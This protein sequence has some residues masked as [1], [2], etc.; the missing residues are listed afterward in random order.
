MVFFFSPKD[1]TSD[2]VE[3]ETLGTEFLDYGRHQISYEDFL[4]KVMIYVIIKVLLILY[5]IKN[6]PIY[7]IRIREKI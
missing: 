2:K 3:N 4:D 5:R 6:F 7:F 1:F